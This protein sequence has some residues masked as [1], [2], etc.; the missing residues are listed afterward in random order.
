[1]VF[2][3]EVILQELLMSNSVEEAIAVL[4]SCDVID[5]V[6]FHLANNIHADHDNP[7]VRTTYPA[8]WVTYYLLHNMITSDPVLRHANEASEP[9]CWSKLQISGKEQVFMDKAKDFG[10]GMSGYSVPCKDKN[11]RRSVLSLNSTLSHD[12][13]AGFVTAH[14]A[15]LY[16]LAQD[17]HVKGVSEAFAGAGDIPQLSPREYEC[18]KWTSLGKSYSDIAIILAL[19]EHTIRSYLKM[20]R[21]KLDSVTL[22]QAVT[23]ATNLGLI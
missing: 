21:L 22:A 6:T 11:G 3:Y 12:D 16:N 20:A 9:F 2:D 1:M 15:D 23:K 7:F 19:S 10:I 14:S 8:D 5:N 17:L 13:W 4:Q 18:L